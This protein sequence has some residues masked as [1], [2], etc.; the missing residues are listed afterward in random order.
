MAKLLVKRDARGWYREGDYN[1]AAEEVVLVA[2]N[3]SGAAMEQA[4][5]DK[6]KKGERK[7]KRKRKRKREG[8]MSREWDKL[9]RELEWVKEKLIGIYFFE[10]NKIL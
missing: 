9:V 6:G 4:T 2:A 8:G 3:S 7:T 10:I 5:S 1:V